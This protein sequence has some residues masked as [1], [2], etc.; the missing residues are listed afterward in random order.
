MHLDDL[1]QNLADGRFEELSSAVN[2]LPVDHL[3]LFLNILT[4]DERV[5]IFRLLNSDLAVD[6]LKSVDTGFAASILEHL[7]DPEIIFFLEKLDPYDAV[8][9]I[10]LFPEELFERVLLNLEPDK[11]TRILLLFG[12]PEDSVGRYIDLDVV[13]VYVDMTVEDALNIVRSSPV[14]SD[15]LE[16]VV[17]VDREKKFLGSI[18]LPVLVKANPS[19]IIKFLRQDVS[20]LSVTASVKEAI[21]TFSETSKP[22]LP[23][24]DSNQRV[25]GVVRAAN[26]LDVAGDIQA[27]KITAFGGTFQSENLDYRT[28]TIREIFSARF[29]WLAVLVIFGALVSGY[30]SAQEEV[31][32]KAITLAAFIPP[33]VDMGGNAGSQAASY[34]I[35]ALGTGQIAPSVLTLVSLLKKDLMVASLLG[36]SLAFL[37]GLLS[38]LFKDVNFMIL[39]T[40]SLSMLLVVIIGSLVGFLLPFAAV[41]LK[42]DPAVLSA[43]V[44]TSLMD[45]IGVIIYVGIARIFVL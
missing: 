17:V 37:E 43:P 12:Y 9:I 45:L 25:V 19:E 26:L 20:C 6:V 14:E 18:T 15:E 44:I 27:E 7:T 33:I 16:I 28:N 36:L 5:S 11:K 13:S 3:V 41:K 39:L 38:F 2:L 32:A 8:K 21:D 29:L 10:E 42:Q 4:Q 1:K 34:V 31:F 30:L 22:I 23:V 40:V 24:V 35:R